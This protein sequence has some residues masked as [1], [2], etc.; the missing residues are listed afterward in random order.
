MMMDS[1]LR[2]LFIDTP[3]NSSGDTVNPEVINFIFLASISAQVSKIRKY[4]EDRTPAGETIQH[5]LVATTAVKRLDLLKPLRCIT[6][7]NKGSTQAK[8]WINNQ[9]KNPIKIDRNNKAII[10]FDTPKIKTVFY[11]GSGTLELLG[12]V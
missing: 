7:K 12:L 6:I 11:S 8:I 9:A 10:K 5:D 3:Q 1:R 4:L 2:S